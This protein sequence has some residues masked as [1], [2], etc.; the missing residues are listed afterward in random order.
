MVLPVGRAGVWGQLPQ[1]PRRSR[2]GQKQVSEPAHDKGLEASA[3]VG[4]PKSQ[5]REPLPFPPASSSPAEMPP[6][7]TTTPGC[8]L[9]R[10]AKPFPA[11]FTAQEEH[12]P[13]PEDGPRESH[14]LIFLVSDTFPSRDVG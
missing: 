7:S 14:L 12:I 13:F 10:D 2:W 11:C 5:V 3:V 6:F 4:T 1:G 8:V 9:A